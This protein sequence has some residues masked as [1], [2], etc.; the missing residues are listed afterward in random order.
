MPPFNRADRNARSSTRRQQDHD[1]FHQ[2]RQT[3]RNFHS[4]VDTGDD[5]E[6]TDFDDYSDADHPGHQPQ[7]PHHNAGTDGDDAAD[8]L[9][10]LRDQLQ[11]ARNEAQQAK[12]DAEEA[13][14]QAREA[15]PPPSAGT[16]P[17]PASLKT[18]VAEQRLQHAA[19]N[20]G[21][22]KLAPGPEQHVN[23]IKTTA[24]M[25][26][27]MTDVLACLLYTSDA[28]DE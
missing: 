21:K 24:S 22:L 12:A 6:Q 20:F 3:R 10:R 13:R 5:T 11:A 2:R 17:R 19:E 8:E 18:Q 4:D 15:V 7:Q 16:A 23:N 25:A 1:R 28:A 26:R 27:G 14:R 9:Q